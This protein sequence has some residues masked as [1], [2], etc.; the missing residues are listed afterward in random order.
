MRSHSLDNS[1]QIRNDNN[2]LPIISDADWLIPLYTGDLDEDLCQFSTLAEADSI[3]GRLSVTGKMPGPS[4]NLPASA[5][6]TGSTLRHTPGT[7]CYTCYA[8]DNYE[9]LKQ[10]C[11]AAGTKHKLSN[12]IDSDVRRA[13]ARRL[14]LLREPLWVP[15]LVYILRYSDN[16]AGIRWMRW[17]SSGDVQSLN[18][19]KNILLVAEHTPNTKHWLPTMERKW[20]KQVTPPSN[21]VI[22]LSGALVDRPK[23][24]DFDC[25]S[26]ISTSKIPSHGGF[27][28]PAPDNEEYACGDCRACWQPEVA[29]VDYYQKQLAS[30]DKALNLNSKTED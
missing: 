16:G 21:L 1:E 10:A 4:F 8:P 30:R 23:P 24:S 17:M 11:K 9:W 14:H 7:P 12:F 25:T 15:A 22:R 5:C 6:P 18:H 27:R 26:T 29:H 2:I 28:C 3:F 13:S 20:V 19:L